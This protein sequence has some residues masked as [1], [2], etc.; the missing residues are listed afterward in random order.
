MK[1][2]LVNGWEILLGAAQFPDPADF[3]KMVESA[4]RQTEKDPDAFFDE[5][6]RELTKAESYSVEIGG[7]RTN[8]ITVKYTGDPVGY[9]NDDEEFYLNSLDRSRVNGNQPNNL[10][11]A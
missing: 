8:R 4:I 1:I 5:L 10:Q 3:V 11:G 7:P 9:E 2:Q 6:N